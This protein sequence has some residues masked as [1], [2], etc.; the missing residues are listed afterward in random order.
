MA[1]ATVP[2]KNPPAKV[3]KVT[4]DKPKGRAKHP[5]VGSSTP[6]VY[7][8]KAVP[9]DYN[10]DTMAKLKKKDFAKDHEDQ[11]FEYRA[12][13]AEHLAKQLRAKAEEIRTIGSGENKN[14]MKKAI[15]MAQK[16]AELQA[17][18][19]KRGVDVAGIVA[20]AQAEMAAKLAAA[21]A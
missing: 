8:F 19:T 3:T 2:S 5:L 18:L 4:G 12:L 13:G 14:E 6:S 11:F 21:G 15:R 16:F 17:A 20:K 9:T 10:F 7:P 1:T